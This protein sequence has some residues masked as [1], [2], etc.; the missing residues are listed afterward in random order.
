MFT[1]MLLKVD[2]HPW[3]H[4]CAKKWMH[5]MWYV[6]IHE[7]W[8]LPLVVRRVG[9]YLHVLILIMLYLVVEHEA[10]E[11]FSFYLLMVCLAWKMFGWASVDYCI[12]WGWWISDRI[13]KISLVLILCCVLT[14]IL[15]PPC[16][17]NTKVLP[18]GGLYNVSVIL[19]PMEG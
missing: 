15:S 1:S 18:Y 19:L 10:E 5:H 8:L 9:D 13:F 16:H 14:N 12:V 7:I 17:Y 11:S 3:S 2:M 6:G 4:S